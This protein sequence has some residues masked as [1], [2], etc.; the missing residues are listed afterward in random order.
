MDAFVVLLLVI[1]IICWACY[2]RKLSKAVYGIAA[3]DIFLRIV[4][5]IGSHIGSNAVATFFSRFPNSLLAVADKYT[6]GVVYLIIA[7]AFIFLMIYFLVMTLGIFF[8]K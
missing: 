8:K 7:W 6:S 1:I 3:L 4:A 5:F 2:R